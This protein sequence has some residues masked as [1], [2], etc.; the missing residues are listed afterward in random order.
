M[1]YILHPGKQN[2]NLAGCYFSSCHVADGFTG[3]LQHSF[4]QNLPGDMIYSRTDES[5]CQVSIVIPL[6]YT[7]GPLV[8]DAVIWSPMSVNQVLCKSLDS[9]TGIGT[10]GKQTTNLYPEYLSFS[11]RT[12]AVCPCRGNYHQVASHS[13]QGPVSY[14]GFWRC[15]VWLAGHY[16]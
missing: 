8:W 10:T 6:S 12:L 3:L 11:V 9:D 2:L 15:W 5:Q 1:Q 16:T 7:V 4:S 13:L 14:W